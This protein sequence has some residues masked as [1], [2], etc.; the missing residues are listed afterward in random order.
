MSLLRNAVLALTLTALAVGQ[1]SAQ[2]S[3]TF[4]SPLQ[5]GDVV[6]ISVW[7]DTS[8]SGQFPV[9][10]DGQVYLPFLGN[11][12]AAGVSIED[13]RIRIREGFQ[14]AQRN[15]VVTVTPLYRIGVT[16]AVSRPGL[17]LVPPTDG[18]FDVVANAG[19]FNLRA[20]QS[21]VSVVRE[22][23]VINL[24]AEEAIKTGDLLP[25][26]ALALHSGDQILVPFAPDGWRP[27]DWISL[28]NLAISTILLIDRLQD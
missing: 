13:L 11:V 9:E 12:Q 22:G 5:P 3:Q 1:A 16:G 15:A 10:S 28:A 23:Q 19:G 2:E 6:A 8:L 17:Y 26:E 20:D 27:R 14:A 24:N 4:E 21:K 25:L 18:F 7:P